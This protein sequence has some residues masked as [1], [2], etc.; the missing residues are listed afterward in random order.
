MKERLTLFY[1]HQLKLW[2]VMIICRSE[3][4]TVPGYEL[5][6]EQGQGREGGKWGNHLNHITKSYLR[7]CIDLHITKSINTR[8]T[9]R[10]HRSR[11]RLHQEH[12]LPHFRGFWFVMAPH[13]PHLKIGALDGRRRRNPQPQHIASSSSLSVLIK[14]SYNVTLILAKS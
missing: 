8:R 14:S 3:T 12:L 5:S 7:R 6:K 1:I 4:D 9:Q 2:L 11:K 10:K 13:Q